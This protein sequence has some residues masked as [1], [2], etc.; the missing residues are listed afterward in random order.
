MAMTILDPQTALVVVDLQK[1]IVG[2]SVAHPIKP[3]IDNAVMLIEAF[4]AQHLPVVLVNVDNVAPGRT[5]QGWRHGGTFPADFIEFIP[6]LDQHAEDI[7]VTKHTWGA[8]ATTDLDARLKALGVTQVVVIGV[9]TGTGVEATARQ[10]YELGFNVTL[11]VDA[12][13]DTR[14]EA[15]DYSIRNVFPRLGETAT[16]KDI[17]NLLASRTV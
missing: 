8:F 11:A 14:A 4:R 7:V 12:M 10:A 9:A 1:G 16:T 17:I 2:L 15:H 13:T 5:E 3:V 6:E